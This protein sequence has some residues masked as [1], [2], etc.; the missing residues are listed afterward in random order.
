M[1][2]GTSSL[3]RFFIA[4]P[5]VILASCLASSS[6]DPSSA[7]ACAGLNG[8]SNFDYLV[9]A[10]IADSPHL[11]SMTGYRVNTAFVMSSRRH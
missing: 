6:A 5:A 8:P 4:F 2:L 1:P 7:R 3:T 10:S 9:L 11:F